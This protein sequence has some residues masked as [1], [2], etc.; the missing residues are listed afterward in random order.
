[1]LAS[2][3]TAMRKSI[4]SERQMY[5]EKV[6][7]SD[8]RRKE[9]VEQAMRK[10]EQDRKTL[11]E[12][13]Q[14]QVFCLKQEYEREI[15][16][17]KDL[18][19]KFEDQVAS[20]E[21]KLE[22][23]KSR[24]QVM[25]EERLAAARKEFD[26]KA[27]GIRPEVKVRALP[28]IRVPMPTGSRGIWPKSRLW[29]SQLA[30][31]SG[32]VLYMD[33]DLLILKSID[34]FFSY[35]NEGD[36]ILARNLN[37]PFERLGQTSLFR[38]P[39]GSLLPLQE[40]FERDPQGIADKYEFEQRFVTREAPHGVKFFPLLWVGHFKLMCIPPF[41]FNYLF[42]PRKPRL[43]KVLIFPGGLN[44][45][46]ASQGRWSSDYSY[47][48]PWGHMKKTFSPNRPGLS[49]LEFIRHFLRPS[50]W[51]REVWID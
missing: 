17:K 24:H 25:L 22:H 6:A 13:N 47:W 45:D 16:Y 21:D 34:P 8:K 3:L 50:N 41:P 39:V 14:A 9:D 49:K 44:Q 4:I 7:E 36:V 27:D 40:K 46:L 33:L 11:D 5:D 12:E 15:A 32:P 37:T 10:F 51:I 43:P 38:F 2:M 31:L 48:G 26:D 42:P 20:L 30:E 28:P 23:S 35:G 19:A 1:M 29:G 18:I